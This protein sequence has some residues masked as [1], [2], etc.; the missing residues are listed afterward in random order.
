METKLKNK[1]D[2][3]IDYFH[4]KFL[5]EGEKFNFRT[6]QLFKAKSANLKYKVS[7]VDNSAVYL[8]INYIREMLGFYMNQ[9][10]VL[11]KYNLKRNK[12]V[13]SELIKYLDIKAINKLFRNKNEHYFILELY[14]G[15]WSCYYNFNDEK[16]YFAYKALI[17]KFK[18]MLGRDEISFHFSKLLSYCIIKM[19]LHQYSARFGNEF[20]D[21]AE[22]FLIYGYYKNKKVDYIPHDLYRMILRQAIDSGRMKYAKNFIE[23]YTGK[24]EPQLRDRMYNFG[25]AYYFYYSGQ[26]NKSLECLQDTIL[27][28]FYFRY[29]ARHLQ[30]ANNIELGNYDVA[31][32]LIHE[33]MVSV[34]NNDMMTEE[35]K[36]KHYNYL[37]L[38]GKLIKYLF[39]NDRIDPGFLRSKIKRNDKIVQNQWLIELCNKIISNRIPRVFPQKSRLSRTA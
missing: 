26:Y 35:L 36:K 21:V 12:T 32:V 8:T 15:L 6:I 16:C 1:G 27:E 31:E 23:K 7:C 25:N 4:G 18:R 38:I 14:Y 11:S 19:R 28:N 22:E 30:I 3:D 2:M 9:S 13:V 33:Y 24:V 20:L 29:D 17:L 10:M 5:M 39:G 37:N 34:D